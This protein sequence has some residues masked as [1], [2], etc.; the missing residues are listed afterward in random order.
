MERSINDLGETLLAQLNEIAWGATIRSQ[1]RLT[2]S[3]PGASREF[4]SKLPTSTS[5]SR[6]SEVALPRKRISSSLSKPSTSH[7]SS[8]EFAM[9]RASTRMTS[10][11]RSFV[12]RKLA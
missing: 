7:R 6:D 9:C 12:L 10:S 8:I 4:L 1:R 5:R 11:R 2:T 3:S